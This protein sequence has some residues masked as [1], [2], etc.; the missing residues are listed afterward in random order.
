MLKACFRMNVLD[1]RLE[2]LRGFPLL[3]AAD[4]LLSCNLQLA[5]HLMRI[6]AVKLSNV[7]IDVNLDA[8]YVQ[9]G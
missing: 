9:F 3:P 4:F 5:A 1:L 2:L 6:I 7:Y 8:F